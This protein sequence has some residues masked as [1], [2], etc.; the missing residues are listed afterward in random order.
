MLELLDGSDTSYPE[1]G[2]CFKREIQIPLLYNN[3]NFIS[4]AKSETRHRD[5]ASTHVSH[6]RTVNRLPI[7]FSAR[8]DISTMMLTQLLTEMPSR[9]SAIRITQ[10]VVDSAFPT[11]RTQSIPTLCTFLSVYVLSFSLPNLL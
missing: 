3:T 6:C 9:L 5:I 10:I 2:V 11:V 8:F 4:I 1:S 7:T